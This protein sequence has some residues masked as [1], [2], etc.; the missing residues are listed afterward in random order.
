MMLA[1]R[2][3]TRTKYHLMPCFS[4]R[5]PDIPHLHVMTPGMSLP[6]SPVHPRLMDEVACVSRRQEASGAASCGGAP[7]VVC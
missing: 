2:S 1:I 4:Y 7:T 3:C 6:L 5:S